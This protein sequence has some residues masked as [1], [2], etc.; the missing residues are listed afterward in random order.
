[1]C[2]IQAPDGRW[3]P[4]PYAVALQAARGAPPRA[5]RLETRE[6]PL[7]HPDDCGPVAVVVAHDAR[8][9]AGVLQK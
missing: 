6:P 7:E 2:A 4:V 1:M 5:T 9:E 8:A 3:T